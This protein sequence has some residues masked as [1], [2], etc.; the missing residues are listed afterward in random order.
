[1]AIYVLSDLHL[2]IDA[3]TSKSMEVF[4][5]RWQDYVS[6]IEKNWNA[7]VAPHDTVIVPGDI[8]WA[9]KLEDSYADL[10]FLNALNGKKLLGKG[11]HDFWWAT[12][13]KMKSYFAE[14]G[15]DTLDILYNNAFIVEDRIVCGTR[16]WFP[17]ESKQIT[18]GEVDFDKIINRELGRLRLSLQAATK[19]REQRLNEVG[20]ELP[21]EVFLHFPPVWADTEMTPFVDV[22]LEYGIKNVYFGHIHSSY[23][24]PA[25][26]M[27]KNIK[28]TLTSS[29]FLSFY[30]LKI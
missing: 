25:S 23:S 24:Y 18:V 22:L 9:M 26:F 20:D 15:F 11:N 1:M 5:N 6:K 13:T 2:S 28:F 14:C 4:G 21:I 30:P 29:D 7:V 27:H 17:D 12:A 3:K 19:L 8:S 10:H 16:G